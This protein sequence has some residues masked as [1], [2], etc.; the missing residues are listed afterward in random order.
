MEIGESLLDCARREALE[1]TGLTVNIMRLTSLDSDPCHHA[2][3]AYPDGHVIHYC[4]ATFLVMSLGGRLCVSQE[5]RQV[6]WETVER[7]PAPFLPAH[8]WRLQQALACRNTVTV[9]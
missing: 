5:S 6:C 4:N 7:L 1:E 9:R 2:L 3:V 8:T